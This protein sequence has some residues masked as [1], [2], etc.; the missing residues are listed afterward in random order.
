M[1]ICII[2]N[3]YPPYARGGAEQVVK[4]TVES[5]TRQDHSVVIVTSSPDGNVKVTDGNVTTYRCKPWNIFFYTRAHLHGAGERLLWHVIDMFHIGSA[6]FVAEV[7]EKEKPDVV[8]THNL[9][10]LGFLIPRAIKRFGIRH[11]HTVHDV[12]LVEP[13][14]II[15]KLREHSFRY[16]GPHIKLYSAIMRFLFGSP[17]VVI[18]PS[19]FLLQFYESRGFFPHSKRILM[20]NPV[21]VSLNTGHVHD[22]SQIFRCLYLGQIETHKGVLFLV[23]TFLEWMKDMT[24]KDVRLT[25]VGDGSKLTE[26][27]H[28]AQSP[29]VVCL[30]RIEHSKLPDLFTETDVTIVPSLCYENS[31]TVIVESLSFGVP[32]LA[33]KIEGVAELIDEGKNGLTFETA[34]AVS[35]KEK[36]TWCLTH[37]E[38]LSAM[39]EKAKASLKG[40]SEEEYVTGLLGLYKK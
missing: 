21:T 28:I 20:H 39:R 36:L 24:G 2:T 35:L 16:T 25:I 4:K 9:M 6:R 3:L 13:S 7:L 11:V 19:Q 8:H 26:V 38:E 40:L 23:Q 1:K 17:D 30:G 12:Q 5:L 18:S 34:N 33:S 32:V 22:L 10:G 15:E 31:P 37:P 29:S 27:K 14:G